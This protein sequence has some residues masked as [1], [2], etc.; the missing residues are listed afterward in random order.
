[1]IDKKKLR[2][3]INKSQKAMQNEPTDPSMTVDVKNED[4]EAQIKVYT[5][6]KT[7]DNLN[8]LIEIAR[9]CRLLVPANLNEQNQ[10]VPCLINSQENGLFFPAY[11]SKEQIPKE[12]KSP[13]IINMPY[14][15]INEVA[16][17]QAEHIGGIVINPF[18]DNLVFKM[19]LVQR[20]EEV[21]K[22]RKNVGKV[23]TMQ[24]TPEQYVLFERK[25]F[26]FGFLP[27]HL[28]ENGKELMEQLS[29][30]KE[31]YIDQLFEESYQQKRM[32]PYLPEDFSVMV[33]NISDDLTIARVDL[34]S[35]EMGVPSCYRIYLAWNEKE[36]KGRYM[37]IEKTKDAGS[38]FM[39]EMG[40]DWKHINHGQAPVEGAELQTILDI[41]EEKL[42]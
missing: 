9:K 11:T 29:E 17:R 38:N 37:T 5:K 34:P 35:R 2:N 19:P 25:Q 14:L 12:P 27:R 32:Y 28:F 33:L 10:P 3:A 15:A 30:K 18:T 1:M 6:E 39:G 24:L 41:L 21:E 26:E 13:A 23:K 22:A 40:S 8:Q 31:E 20:I 36:Q 4:L 16:C 42:S 7:G